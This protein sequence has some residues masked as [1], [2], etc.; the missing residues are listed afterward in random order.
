M[1]SKRIL[2]KMNTMFLLVGDDHLHQAILT[3]HR[4]Y[5]HL[6]FFF[7]FPIVIAN[8]QLVFC[9]IQLFCENLLNHLNLDLKNFFFSKFVSLTSNCCF[10]SCVFSRF[11]LE[12]VEN[13]FKESVSFESCSFFFFLILQF[14]S[15]IECLVE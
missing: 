7:Q 2:N 15:T 1:E 12:E 11:C 13:C 14:H 5:L 10:S 8:F 6:L 4:K 9:R 3:I